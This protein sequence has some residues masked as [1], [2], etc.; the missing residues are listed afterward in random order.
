MPS[1]GPISTTTYL[2]LLEFTLIECAH[3]LLRLEA[4]ERALVP[5]EL[6]ELF[7]VVVYHLGL[8]LFLITC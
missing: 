4:L 3:P 8:L 6:Q 7:D 2:L 1:H 5:I